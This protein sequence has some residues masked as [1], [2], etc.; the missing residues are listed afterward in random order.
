MSSWKEN[1]HAAPAHAL[2]T[3]GGQ[4]V[5]GPSACKTAPIED[6]HPFER[7]E[8][9]ENHDAQDAREQV[10]GVQVVRKAHVVC[11]GHDDP[12]DRDRSYDGVV[13][14][15]DWIVRYPRFHQTTQPCAR[16]FERK[17][18]GVVARVDGQYDG[19]KRECPRNQRV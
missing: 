6:E 19:R 12:C 11:C 16:S 3:G 7:Q 9:Q 13:D 14:E 2:E 1:E 4:G 10:P 15:V 8:D 18:G 5:P 17:C